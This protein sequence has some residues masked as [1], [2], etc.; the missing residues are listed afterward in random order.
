MDSPTAPTGRGGPAQGSFESDGGHGSPTARELVRLQQTLYESRNPT[1]RWLHRTRKDWVEERIRKVGHGGAA[2][3]VGPGSGVYLP[4]LQEA[5]SSVVATDIQA[6]HL[7]DLKP[8]FP[9]VRLV[10]DDITSTRM[11]PESFDF[12]LCSEV[13][14]H[15]RDS[16]KA[17]GQMTRLLRP[18]GALLLTT[19][20]RFSTLEL[21]SKVAF[22]PFVVPVVRMVYREPVLKQGHVN[23][24]TRKE[25]RRQLFL[26]GL[27]I[28]EEHLTG[29]YLPLLAEFG[30][31]MGRRVAER[32]EGPLRRGFMR[33][34]LWTQYYLARKG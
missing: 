25:A 13:I 3:E 2:L 32:M 19:P 27:G 31:E 15:I 23:L 10:E 14:E 30:G 11:E 4:V 18:G 5:F 1:R 6:A 29:V 24:L 8:R 33:W 9:N 16:E 34:I 22:L 17:I 26:A 28:E 21:A 20:Q 7:Q 12:I